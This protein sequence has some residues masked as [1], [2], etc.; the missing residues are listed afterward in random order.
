MKRI[1]ILTMGLLALGLAGCATTG[2]T[3]T[4]TATY[5][6][7]E[8]LNTAMPGIIELKPYMDPTTQQQVGNALAAAVQDCQTIPYPS[9]T[10]QAVTN[11]LNVGLAEAAKLEASK[12]AK[13]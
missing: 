8:D 13:K 12:G 6:A 9:N 11:A 1:A 2:T 10:M 3:N 4:Q 7:C 5:N